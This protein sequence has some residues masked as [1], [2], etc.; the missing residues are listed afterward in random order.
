MDIEYTFD[1]TSQIP[2]IIKNIIVDGSVVD[3]TV[4]DLSHESKNLPDE[5]IQEFSNI[6]IEKF[7][8]LVSEL[9]NNELNQYRFSSLKQP[10]E[11]ICMLNTSC[12]DI[13]S[14]RKE[15]NEGS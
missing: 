15:M 7:N 1:H 2:S 8:E 5:I 9:I 11:T 4:L 12:N 10:L 14:S 6:L 3:S 13:I